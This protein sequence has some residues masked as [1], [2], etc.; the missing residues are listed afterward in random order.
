M[1]Q[2]RSTQSVDFFAYENI[3]VGNSST[4][5]TAATHSPSNQRGAQYALITVETDSIK[6]RFDG[7]AAS[8]TN[9]HVVTTND[10]IELEGSNAIANFRA[11]RVTN[12]ATIR[13]SY[14]R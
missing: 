5:L 9:G 1:A 8:A 7:G 3:T 13:V 2:F 4:S 10:T 11:I 12:D 14:A 6:A